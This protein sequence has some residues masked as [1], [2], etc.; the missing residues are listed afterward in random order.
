M[1]AFNQAVAAA[2]LTGQ[3]KGADTLAGRGMTQDELTARLQRDLAEA[4]V[5][6]I[7]GYDDQGRP[8]Q[9]RQAEMDAF[10]KAMA[11]AGVTGQYEGAD[12]FQRTL[13]EAGLTG[14]YEGADT[15][16]GR[17]SA[18]ALLASRLQRDLA[19]ADVTGVYGYDD[20]GRPISTRQAAMDAFNQSVA[21]AGLTGQFED[22]PTMSREAF[23]MDRTN[24]LISQILSAAD[25]TQEGR[26]DPL[27]GW[28]GEQIEDPTLR[29]ALDDALLGYNPELVNSFINPDL[30]DGN[31][32]NGDG[33]SLYFDIEEQFGAYP[34]QGS[35]KAQ[36]RLHDI[37]KELD[38]LHQGIGITE[39]GKVIINERQVKRLITE[40]QQIYKDAED[41]IDWSG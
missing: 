5:T 13:A 41:D 23:E 40:I 19:E 4:D 6:G 26:M 2:G 32:E 21:R 14:Q 28:L 3:Y 7:Y 24:Q 39:Q 8:I 12:T 17:Q 25:K 33:G 20:Q 35:S 11:E 31:G 27:A 36:Q 29:A 15:L 9:T 1:D 34:G 37:Q 10:N 22:A 30:E 16:A 38:T 18:E